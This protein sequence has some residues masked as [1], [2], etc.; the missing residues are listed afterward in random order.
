MTVSS[1]IPPLKTLLHDKIEKNA[2]RTDG[3]NEREV[4]SEEERGVIMKN[5][6][7]LSLYLMHFFTFSSMTEGREVHMRLSSWSGR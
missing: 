1:G 3:T 4:D 5:E 6:R 7:P 2:S